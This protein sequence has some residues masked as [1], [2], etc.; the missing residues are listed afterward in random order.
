[1]EFNKSNRFNND[2]INQV[3]QNLIHYKGEIGE[4]DYDPKIWK[5]EDN[6]LIFKNRKIKSLP[7]NLELPKG[8]INTSDM[9]YKCT[10][11]RD[12]TPLE[13]WDTS[14]VTDMDSMFCDCIKLEDIYPLQDWDVSNVENMSD[15][16]SG[17][18]TFNQDISSWNVSNV[19]YSSNIFYNC[20]IEEKYKPNFR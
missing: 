5:I 13:N 20:P 6:H 11:L 9:F 7:E 10:N 18:K 15:M 4:F 2:N 1:M 17:C 12:I 14:N 8:C 16:F 3:N 19:K